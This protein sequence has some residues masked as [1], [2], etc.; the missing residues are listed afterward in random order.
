MLAKSKAAEGGRSI[1]G[2]NKALNL[3]EEIRQ[4]HPNIGL[5]LKKFGGKGIN[6]VTMGKRVIN[7]IETTMIQKKQQLKNALQQECECK[8]KLAYGTP[9]L[10]NPL[11][12]KFGPSGTNKES[13]K[14]TDGTFKPTN[15]IDNGTKTWLKAMMKTD[16]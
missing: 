5:T 6:M 14:V 9:L 1:A 7:K 15:N 13:S 2:H 4:Q 16:K 10:S 3:M 12:K 8:Y 11:I